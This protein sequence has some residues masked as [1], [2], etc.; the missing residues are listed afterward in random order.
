MAERLAPSSAM[1]AIVAS[2]WVSRVRD[3]PDLVEPGA[4]TR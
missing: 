2:G 4:P 1:E 3:M